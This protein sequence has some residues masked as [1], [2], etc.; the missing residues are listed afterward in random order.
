MAANRAKQEETALK[1]MR[2]DMRLVREM[3]DE[4]VGT[5]DEREKAIRDRCIEAG[6]DPDKQYPAESIH[7]AG[8]DLAEEVPAHWEVA[9]G[10]S[11]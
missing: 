6:Y 5:D 7:R 8:S 11:Y 4:N 3:N 2:R 9:S 1:M 10:W